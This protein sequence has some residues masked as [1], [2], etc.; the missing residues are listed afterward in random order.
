MDTG[1]R[2]EY[3]VQLAPDSIPELTVRY[4]YR[5]AA[6]EAFA[7]LCGLCGIWMGF[8]MLGSLRAGAR[9]AAARTRVRQ[10]AASARQRPTVV[11]VVKNRISLQ[12]TTA[13]AAAGGGGARRVTRL[14]AP[15]FP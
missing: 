11:T 5:M 9:W 4:V 14:W 10:V 12:A 2:L 1:Q 6:I 3:K 15:R 13:A 7:A 8:S